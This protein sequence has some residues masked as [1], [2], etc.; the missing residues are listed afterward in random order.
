[1]RAAQKKTMARGPGEMGWFKLPMRVRAW[2][3]R[4]DK[5]D[6]CPIE[7]PLCC[8][9]AIETVASVALCQRR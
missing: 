9:G 7:A 3:G 5:T 4:R 2:A 8:T 1:V 6:A